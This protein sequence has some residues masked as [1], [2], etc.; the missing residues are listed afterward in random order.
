MMTCYACGSCHRL[1]IFTLRG[2]QFPT[3]AAVSEYDER[4]SRIARF[5]PRQVQ[6]IRNREQQ[7]EFRFRNAVSEYDDIITSKRK[8]LENQTINTLLFDTHACI[9]CSRAM[10]FRIDLDGFA[11]EAKMSTSLAISN[12]DIRHRYD[13]W[14]CR[15]IDAYQEQRS[16]MDVSK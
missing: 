13:M 1:F 16:A 5:F 2:D 10:C 12:F 8:L 9:S 4:T 7:A 6:D 3:S 14:R 11:K 15:C